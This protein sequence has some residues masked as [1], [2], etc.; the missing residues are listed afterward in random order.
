[1]KVKLD[2]PTKRS[3]GQNQHGMPWKPS[4][5]GLLAGSTSAEDEATGEQA[6][7]LADVSTLIM[8]QT[9]VAGGISWPALNQTVCALR[10]LYRVT[11]KQSD[12]PERIPYARE[13]QKLPVVLGA[14]EVVRFL[15][16]VPN[17]RSRA[18]LTTAYAAGQLCRHGATPPGTHPPC[19]RARRRTLCSHAQEPRAA[20]GLI[21]S[22]LFG[23]PFEDRSRAL[24]PVM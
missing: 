11:L 7:D 3:S 19:S 22:K 9:T 6:E 12:L 14:N 4:F 15:E 2:R 5:C 23:T 10:L 1:M 20:K 21:S 17:L 18:A 13:P 8:G 16:A 24:A